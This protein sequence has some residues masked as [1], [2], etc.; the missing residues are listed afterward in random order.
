[1]SKKLVTYRLEKISRK[2]I[3]DHKREFL[4]FLEVQFS[5]RRQHG[6]YA[7]Y[8]D[9]ELY[10][11]GRAVDLQRRIHQHLKDKHYAQ[12]TH[13]SLYIINDEKNMGDIESL[14]VRIADPKGNTVKPRGKSDGKVLKTL[15][16][17]IKQKVLQEFEGY[18]SENKK[19]NK[20]KTGKHPDLKKFFRTNKTLVRTYKGKEYK[21]KLLVSGKI[22]Y[23]RKIYSTPTAAA[24]KVVD[25]S[26][27]NGWSFW[28]IQDDNNNWVR[29]KDL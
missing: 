17:F 27:V 8:D 7:L 25:R 26:T 21:A 20:S 10:Y 19:R 12:W 2:L 1:M 9:N 13:F 23:K 14:L 4:Q 29:L 22:K 18:F 3:E 15:R 24:M 6:I 5:K 16:N 28:Y 11:V